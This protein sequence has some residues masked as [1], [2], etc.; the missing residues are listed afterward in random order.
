MKKIR[1]P[2]SEKKYRV[3]NYIFLVFL[4]I[5]TLLVSSFVTSQLIPLWTMKIKEKAYDITTLHSS[6]S[7]NAS[8][9]E[10]I[11]RSTLRP[12]RVEV[13]T[14]FDRLCG[15]KL[16]FEKILTLT[17]KEKPDILIFFGRIGANGKTQRKISSFFYA[18]KRFQVKPERIFV[19]PDKELYEY[20]LASSGILLYYVDFFRDFG[21]EVEFEGIEKIRDSLRFVLASSMERIDYLEG[22]LRGTV[23]FLADKPEGFVIPELFVIKERPEEKPWEAVQ[24]IFLVAEKG[25]LFLNLY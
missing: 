21:A 8:T 19:V 20:L 12:I 3:L 10:N 4:F 17:I 24:H 6:Y 9:Y 2:V 7:R 25:V 1:I 16:A 18:L 14:D 13:I 11:W 23:I 5:L 22:L 15:S